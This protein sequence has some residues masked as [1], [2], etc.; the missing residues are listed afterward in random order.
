MAVFKSVSRRVARPRYG[1]EI[2][3]SVRDGLG[4]ILRA[5]KERTRSTRNGAWASALGMGV[6]S[7]VVYKIAPARGPADYIYHCAA[8]A[9]AAT[10]SYKSGSSMVRK[11]TNELEGALRNYAKENSNLRGF[12]ERSKYV[13]IDSNGRLAGTNTARLIPGIGR[14]RLSTNRILSKK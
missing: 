1:G 14:I 5:R 13:F 10:L 7:S 6:A 12:L 9:I 11:A 2:S 8:I 4:Q 3:P